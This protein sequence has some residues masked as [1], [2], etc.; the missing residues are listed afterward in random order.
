MTTRVPREPN[1][2][3]PSLNALLAFETAARH[4][5]F[6]RAARE[7]G[8]TQT[9]ISH[10]VRGLEQQLGTSLFRRSAQRISLTAE[11]QA[12]ATE[13]GVVFARLR[14]ANR[15]LRSVTV[16]ERPAVSV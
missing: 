12:W 9:A 16:S 2:P 6:T 8:V 3:L 5:S 13:L 11:G 1:P 14:E 10:Q 15:R 7:L 4:G